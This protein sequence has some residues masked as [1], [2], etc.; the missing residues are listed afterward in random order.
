ML[1]CSNLTRSILDSV[2]IETL[3]R[4]LKNSLR[5]NLAIGIVTHDT[6]KTIQNLQ[7]KRSSSSPLPYHRS[8][9]S[10]S[11]S[12]PDTIAILLSGDV[13][14]VATTAATTVAIGAAAAIGAAHDGRND[15]VPTW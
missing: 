12:L 3:G 11:L 4:V 1:G 6:Y 2:R 15:R 8:S 10:A 7:D 13:Q 14:I 5:R 9:T